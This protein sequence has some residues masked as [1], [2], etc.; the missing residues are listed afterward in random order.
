MDNIRNITVQLHGH[1][2]N[3]DH[4]CLEENDYSLIISRIFIFL[5]PLLA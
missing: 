4:L 5:L 3:I 1:L 2:L